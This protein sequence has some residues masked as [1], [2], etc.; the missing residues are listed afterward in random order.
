MKTY[1]DMYRLFK[2]SRAFTDFRKL[3]G[4]LQF[5][6]YPD[7]ILRAMLPELRSWMKTDWHSL[8]THTLDQGDKRAPL[9][10]KKA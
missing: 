4:M 7:S 6:S 9:Y 2:E 10:L 8:P 5:A 1:D 3:V